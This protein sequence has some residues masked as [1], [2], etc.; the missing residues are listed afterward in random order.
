VDNGE[1]L[2]TRRDIDRVIK[3]M[4][5]VAQPQEGTTRR[6]MEKLASV[7]QPQAETKHK[8]DGEGDDQE[9]GLRYTATTRGD[10]AQEGRWRGSRRPPVYGN[11]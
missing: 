1:A 9:A 4:A 6:K 3:K 11:H 2:G 5:P 7:M 8:Q 10:R